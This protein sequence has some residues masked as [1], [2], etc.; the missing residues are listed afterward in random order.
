MNQ[1]LPTLISNQRRLPRAPSHLLSMGAHTTL[2]LRPAGLPAMMNQ[3]LHRKLS[4]A[5]HYQVAMG[6]TPFPSSEFFNPKPQRDCDADSLFS[7]TRMCV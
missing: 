2:S 5:H 4:E 1:S 6:D 3:T 7:R